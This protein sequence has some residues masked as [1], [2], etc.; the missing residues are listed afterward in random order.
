MKIAHLI[1]SAFL[2]AGLSTAPLAFADSD[3]SDSSTLPKNLQAS[4]HTGRTTYVNVHT[5]KELQ[6]S[7][8]VALTDAAQ[9]A[10]PFTTGG[11]DD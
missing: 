9:D 4:D 1:A 6:A 10:H 5:G 8:N 3:T 11:G 7:A 2:I